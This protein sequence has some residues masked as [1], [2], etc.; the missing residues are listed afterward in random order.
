MSMAACSSS[1][2]DNISTDFS[3]DIDRHDMEYND[4]Y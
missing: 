1:R 4:A 2:Y 3:R